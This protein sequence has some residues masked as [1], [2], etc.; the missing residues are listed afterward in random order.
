MERLKVLSFLHASLIATISPCAVGSFVAVTLLLPSAIIFPSFT[1][2]LILFLVIGFSYSSSEPQ[3]INTLLSAISN[4]FNISGWLFLV[5]IVVIV[6][7]IHWS[8]TYIRHLK[9]SF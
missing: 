6:L 2:T 5:P 7:I 3:E 4:S 1:I 8:K 9:I